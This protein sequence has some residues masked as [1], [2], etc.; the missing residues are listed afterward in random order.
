MIESISTNGTEVI[1]NI[2]TELGGVKFSIN[3]RWDTG[4]NMFAEL[5]REHLKELALIRK[6][7]NSER[8]ADD[9]LCYLA[10]LKISNLKSRLK[11][12]NGSKHCWK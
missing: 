2:T 5:L 9:C 8:I 6:D 10:P 4:S 11:K 12:W 1:L 3:F 7:R